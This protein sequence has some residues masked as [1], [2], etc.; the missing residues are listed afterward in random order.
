MVRKTQEHH[1]NHRMVMAK[2]ILVKAWKA[3][4]RVCG[5]NGLFRVARAKQQSYHP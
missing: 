2:N 1:L 3:V 4:A 5:P